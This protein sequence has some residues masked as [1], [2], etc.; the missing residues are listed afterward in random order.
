VSQKHQI[1]IFE[2]IKEKNMILSF[3]LLFTYIL[4]LRFTTCFTSQPRQGLIIK[5]LMAENYRGN[6]HWIELGIN[7]TGRIVPC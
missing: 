3:D 1:N 4:L 2:N 7:S 6:G 5:P